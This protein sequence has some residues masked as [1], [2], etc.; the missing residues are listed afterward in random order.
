MYVSATARTTSG[1]DGIPV[2]NPGKKIPRVG[3]PAISDPVAG[4]VVFQPSADVLWTIC[5]FIS[6]GQSVPTRP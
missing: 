5:R 6:S 3:R 4:N 2:E 1:L